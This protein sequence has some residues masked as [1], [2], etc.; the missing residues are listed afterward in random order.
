MHYIPV[1]VL[2]P[3]ACVFLVSGCSWVN[4]PGWEAPGTTWFSR[5]PARP[6]AAPMVVQPAAPQTKEDRCAD[7]AWV[8]AAAFPQDRQ[9]AYGQAFTRCMQAGS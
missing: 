8:A 2:A 5:G 4:A 6:A 3:V 7:Q 1:R 9:L